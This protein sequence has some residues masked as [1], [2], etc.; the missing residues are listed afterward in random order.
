[1]SKIIKHTFHKIYFKKFNE[2][3]SCSI[4]LAI[5]LIQTTFTMRK[6]LMNMSFSW[7]SSKCYISEYK[8]FSFKKQLYRNTYNC[9]E[10]ELLQNVDGNDTESQHEK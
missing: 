9:L 8:N 4:I 3:Q 1:M 6:F 7:L 5:R 2:G 10:L